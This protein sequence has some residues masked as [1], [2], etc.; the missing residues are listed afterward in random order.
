MIVAAV[1]GVI[2]TL[3]DLFLREYREITYVR[4]INGTI[5]K[6]IDKTEVHFNETDVIDQT[7]SRSHCYFEKSSRKAVFVAS[8]VIM[9]LIM[10]VVICLYARI[11]RI[12]LTKLKISHNSTQRPWTNVR[13]LPA[14]QEVE[15]GIESQHITERVNGNNRSDAH[16]AFSG[17]CNREDQRRQ[18]KEVIETTNAKRNIQRQQ[19]QKAKLKFIV[20]FLII[21]I[22]YG[23]SYI[24][25][26]VF[27]LIDVDQQNTSRKERKAQFFLQR[28]V[29]LFGFMNHIINPFI[30]GCFDAIF[31]EKCKEI[32]YRNRCK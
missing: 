13:D 3:P 5:V 19:K 14:P 16:A 6:N 24:P 1:G 8:L 11:L 29:V 21:V 20:M 15:L 9:L 18:E 32:F 30:Y 7:I 17:I 27:A 25:F 10:F 22:F 31:R 23:A 12:I 2:A 4:Y 28:V 26:H